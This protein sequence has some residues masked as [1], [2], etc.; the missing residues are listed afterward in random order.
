MSQLNPPRKVAL[1]ALS[2]CERQGAW[3]DGVLKKAIR[4][5]G[6]D[7]R[8]A[9]LC[10]RLCYG[11]LQNKMLLDFYLA[12]FCKMPLGKL[13][14]KVLQSLRLGAYQLCFLDRVPQRAAV[15]ES[16]E[17]AK[18]Y[19]KN[20]RAAG[21][22]NGVL[23]AMA[24]AGEALPRPQD[25]ATRYSHP[26]WLVQAFSSALHGEVEPL[27]AADNEQ[28]PVTAQVNTCKA[29]VEQAEA[30]LRAQGVGVER[31][32][33]LEGC[34]ILTETGNLEGLEAFS[35]GWIYIQDPAARLAVLAAGPRPGMRVLDACAA[36]GGKSFAAAIAM[37]DRGEI[38]SRDLHPHKEKLIR[39]GAARLGLSC[40]ST[41]VA[42]ARASDPALEGAFD[43]VMADVP[44]SG[45]GII[46]KKPDIRYKD[47][48][49]LAGLP[50]VQGEILDQMARCVR[51]GGTLLYATCTL[52]ER[53]NE[54]VV[55]AFL[56][57]H[58]GFTPIGFTLP[59]P[60]GE[61][62]GGL[63]TLWPHLHGTDGFFFALLKRTEG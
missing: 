23:R 16:V 19:A 53:E 48:A 28:P 47:P 36:P 26:E 37:G 24:R 4:E 15:D 40:I 11:V 12:A 14:D 58:P 13:E 2:A 32:P 62:P 51:P 10:T 9:A 27:L 33:W 25:L 21:L 49:P 42:D 59:G 34:L 55:R 44:C 29:T 20:P 30:S 39:A 31:H 52:L 5:A 57:R 61:V 63:C 41:A 35:R 43:L 46:R 7:G 45:L 56:D 22:V 60:V 1:L 54:G 6:L 17:L 18:A 3:S 50:R 8:D 38:L